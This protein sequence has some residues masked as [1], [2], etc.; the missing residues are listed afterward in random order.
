MFIKTQF[1]VHPHD[2]EIISLVGKGDV[3]WTGAVGVLEVSE[4]SLWVSEDVLGAYESSHGS[5]D[6]HDGSFGGDAC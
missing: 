4:N 1:E 2:C 3:K 5:F 6:T